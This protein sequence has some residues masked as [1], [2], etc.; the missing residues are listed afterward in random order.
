MKNY[1][2]DDLAVRNLLWLSDNWEDIAD[3]E[4]AEKYD[5][6]T[7]MN[8][9]A[10]V[11]G[12]D[13]EEQL[14]FF[15]KLLRGKDAKIQELEKMTREAIDIAKEAQAD[16]R[17][18]LRD[19]ALLGHLRDYDFDGRFEAKLVKL[20]VN[21]YE[22]NDL[23]VDEADREAFMALVKDHVERARK[24]IERFHGKDA[25]DNFMNKV[26]IYLA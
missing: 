26:A 23:Y 4:L 8:K 1:K 22:K 18:D 6:L 17:E 21:W 7:E 16:R 2:N 12:F 9:Y 10:L 24:D 25:S 11:V 13:D 3:T 19:W 14:D 5:D 20:A 15:K